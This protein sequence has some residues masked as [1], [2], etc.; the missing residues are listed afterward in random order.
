MRL[1]STL[2][3]PATGTLSLHPYVSVVGC[4]H[5]RFMLCLVCMQ[6]FVR[7]ASTL[8]VAL[9]KREISPLPRSLLSS[10][11]IKYNSFGLSSQGRS[12]SPPTL[13]I[14]AT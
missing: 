2:K 13:V 11:E 3:P 14:S 1:S 7:R 4:S 12:S 9:W 10:R 5:I 6:S 8:F